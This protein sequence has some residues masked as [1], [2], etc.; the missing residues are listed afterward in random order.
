MRENEECDNDSF[1]TT[2]GNDY[3]HFNDDDN[4]NCNGNYNDF[5]RISPNRGISDNCRI[6]GRG[7]EQQ[8]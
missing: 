1:D 8:I 2:C 4:R 7:V 3:R 6:S 5:V